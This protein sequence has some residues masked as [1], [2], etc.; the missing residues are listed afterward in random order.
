MLIF[1]KNFLTSPKIIHPVKKTRIIEIP[2][3]QEKI[4][5]VK[6]FSGCLKKSKFKTTLKPDEMA[7]SLSRKVSYQK[8]FLSETEMDFSKMKM[9]RRITWMK[10]FS[11]PISV[12]LA[13]SSADNIN[14]TIQS[15]NS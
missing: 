4:W 12:P 8:L 14:E 3:E 6:I 15:T 13:V 1:L 9:S 11:V 5:S 7:Q 10:A 2:N